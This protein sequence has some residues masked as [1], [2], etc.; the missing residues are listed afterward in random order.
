MWARNKGFFALPLV[1]H[2]QKTTKTKHYM[3][4]W[5][6]ITAYS[7]NESIQCLIFYLHLCFPVFSFSSAYVQPIYIKK[8]VYLKIHHLTSMKKM[9]YF[10]AGRKDSQ[11]YQNTLYTEICI[12]MLPYSRNKMVV[13]GKATAK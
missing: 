7:Q 6:K 4:C 3:L 13:L 2:S 12:Q 1:A 9:G 5:Y 8:K 11:T 10:E